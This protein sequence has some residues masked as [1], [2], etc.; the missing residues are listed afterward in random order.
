M[1]EK[2]RFLKSGRERLDPPNVRN[3][4]RQNRA[5]QVQIAIHAILLRFKRFCLQ[6]GTKNDTT[7]DSYRLGY[8]SYRDS[9]DFN[10]HDR[11]LTWTNPTVTPV[12]TFQVASGYTK[13]PTSY[14]GGITYPHFFKQA[15]LPL[16]ILLVLVSERDILLVKETLLLVKETIMDN[17]VSDNGE[18]EDVYNEIGAYGDMNEDKAQVDFL[19]AHSVRTCQIMG[20]MM[21]QKGGHI[22]ISSEKLFKKHVVLKSTIKK[23]RT[24]MCNLLIAWRPNFDFV[25]KIA[26]ESSVTNELGGDVAIAY[27]K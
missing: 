22:I 20:F 27:H 8:D 19:H 10:Y 21:D 23:L 9:C 17:F 13:N 6:F 16:L 25:S 1:K 5:I 2:T 26:N 4:V 3:P 12:I 7:C 15:E 14:A 24:K 11:P 18:D